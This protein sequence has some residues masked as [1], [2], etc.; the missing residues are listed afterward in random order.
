MRSTSGALAASA[1]V[2]LFVLAPGAEA[3]G[4]AVLCVEKEF[5]LG[6]A[7][8]IT[9]PSGSVFD[10]QRPIT[11]DIAGAWHVAESKADKPSAAFVTVG[12]VRLSK[13]HRCAETAVRMFLDGG[14]NRVAAAQAAD[15][16]YWAMSDVRDYRP[17]T[18]PE[19]EYGRLIDD[20][21]V[22]AQ[23]RSDAGGPLS[24]ALPVSNADDR[25]A[26]CRSRA[27]ALA[28]RV[29]AS[30]GRTTSA[31]TFIQHPLAQ[32]SSVSCDIERP[33]WF[34]SWAG[35][36]RPPPSTLDLIT[37]AGSMLTGLDQGELAKLAIRCLKDALR[38][39]AMEN[40]STEFDGVRV[41]CQAF[42]RD[43]GGGSITLWRRFGPVPDLN[44]Q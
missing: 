8:S 21:A 41:E 9:I 32:E 35:S 1:L 2:T 16:D 19:I 31:V 24:V 39:D 4:R 36:S 23:L 11:G 44:L 25:S 30:A 17:G 26:T 29:H 20:V 28:A 37:S 14:L 40:A 18:K 34:V 5:D 42:E 6:R 38:Q 33:Y 10:R 43:G 12:E 3:A 13:V 7:K 27:M 15:N 22:I